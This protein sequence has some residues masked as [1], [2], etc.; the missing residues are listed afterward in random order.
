MPNGR[1]MEKLE[2]DVGTDT[3]T[4]DIL[5]LSAPLLSFLGFS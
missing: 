1:E 2:S 4:P 3:S 5:T